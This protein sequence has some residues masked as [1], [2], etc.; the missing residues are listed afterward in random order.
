MREEW[1]EDVKHD[2]AGVWF[3]TCASHSHTDAH[4]LVSDRRWKQ[5]LYV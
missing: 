2:A 4:C 3:A 1:I 5:A